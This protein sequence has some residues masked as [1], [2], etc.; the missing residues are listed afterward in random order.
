MTILRVVPTRH[1]HTENLTSVE[2]GAD[3]Y[4]KEHPDRREGWGQQNNYNY[5][6]QKQHEQND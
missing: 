1:H 2:R 5:C 3:T 4:Q 6:M